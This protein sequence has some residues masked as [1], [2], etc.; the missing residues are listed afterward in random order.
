MLESGIDQDVTDPELHDSV[1]LESLISCCKQNPLRTKFWLD[2][3]YK[4]LE[5]EDKAAW[6][7]RFHPCRY[8]NRFSIHGVRNDSARRHLYGHTNSNEPVHFETLDMP[9][10]FKPYNGRYD[11]IISDVCMFEGSKYPRVEGMLM[12]SSDESIWSND[13]MTAYYY[14]E[15]PEAAKQTFL[16]KIPVSDTVFYQDFEETSQICPVSGLTIERPIESSHQV[17]ATLLTLEPEPSEE[18]FFKVRVK[19]SKLRCCGPQYILYN[20]PGNIRCVKIVKSL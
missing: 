11:S 4:V 19:V 12:A 10:A 15:T 3:K 1:L 9:T 16:Y 7:V 6:T 8:P 17:P 18:I 13:W 5:S 2:D 14:P 20:L